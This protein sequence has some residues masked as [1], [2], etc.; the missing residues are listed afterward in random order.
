MTSGILSRKLNA[1]AGLWLRSLPLDSSTWASAKAQ[2]KFGLLVPKLYLSDSSSDAGL[3]GVHRS[4][5]IETQ[6]HAGMRG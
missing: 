5:C 3:A 6:V 1:G 4:S 2:E